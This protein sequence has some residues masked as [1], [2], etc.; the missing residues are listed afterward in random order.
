[1]CNLKF[2]TVFILVMTEAYAKNIKMFKY[3]H[4]ATFFIYESIGILTTL[5]FIHSLINFWSIGKTIEAFQNMLLEE[6]LFSFVGLFYFVIVGFS[7]CFHWL[8]NTFVHF[9]LCQC[10]FRGVSIKFKR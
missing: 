6:I 2:S 1:M 4:V 8:K 3:Y 10:K 9:T 7:I 5:A